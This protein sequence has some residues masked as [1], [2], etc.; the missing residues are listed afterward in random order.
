[1]RKRLSLAVLVAAAAISS[2]VPAHAST[3]ATPAD[4]DVRLDR[5]VSQ[6]YDMADRRTYEDAAEWWQARWHAYF[7]SC[8]MH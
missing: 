3:D 7:E 6:F 5:L 8:V 2:A 1:M 4:C